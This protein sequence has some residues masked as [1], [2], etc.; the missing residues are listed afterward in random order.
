MQRISRE[1]VV[2]PSETTRRAPCEEIQAYLLGALHDASLNKKKRY[3]FT[4]KGTE[5]LTFLQKLFQE[6]GYKSWI[7]R[8]RN[9]E[10]YTLE[11]LAKFLDF[12]FDPLTLVT[13][14]EKAAYIRGFFDAE[15]GVPRNVKAGFYIQLVQKDRTKIEKLVRMLSTLDIST[16]K[17]HNPSERVDPDYWRVY[18]RAKSHKNF[19]SKIGSAHPIKGKILQTRVMI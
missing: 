10:V 13:N 16:G 17:I 9:R 14:A 5:W 7:Y 1:V 19:A 8:E 18:V 15:G 2:D 4:Q 11:T 3:R 6:L 12:R